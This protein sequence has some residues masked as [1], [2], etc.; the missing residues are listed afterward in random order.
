MSALPTDELQGVPSDCL[1]A[2]ASTIKAL[3]RPLMRAR[4]V[5]G[6]K[7][8]PQAYEPFSMA[9]VLGFF[10]RHCEEYGPLNPDHL[11]R[12]RDAMLTVLLGREAVARVN[13][14]LDLVRRHE[15]STIQAWHT[16]RR[17]A[18]AQ[19]G[20]EQAIACSWREYMYLE[21]SAYSYSYPRD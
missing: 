4:W 13:E 3:D 8:P 15:I 19:L 17:E 16:G 10:E 20:P 18:D 11:E 14:V 6:W 12:A 2:V 5:H 1:P 21:V 9:Y 7:I